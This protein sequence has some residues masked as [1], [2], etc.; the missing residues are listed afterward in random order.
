MSI[1][2]ILMIQICN[3]IVFP[4]FENFELLLVFLVVFLYVISLLIIVVF[5]IIIWF[6]ILLIFTFRN[7]FCF[8]LA[9]CWLLLHLILHLWCSCITL[10]SFVVLFWFVLDIFILVFWAFLIVFVLLLPLECSSLLI[11]I[12]PI[13]WLLSL[14]VW[15]SV[16]HVTTLGGVVLAQVVVE[17]IT[18]IFIVFILIT[19]FSVFWR[20]LWFALILLRWSILRPRRILFWPIFLILTLRCRPRQRLSI[21]VFWFEVNLIIA[22]PLILFKEFTV[23]AQTRVCLWLVAFVFGK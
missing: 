22:D 14:F 3:W 20:F 19:I 11:P 13:W 8:R 4:A 10:P 5:L 9:L 16:V 2:S 21:L 12:L 18:S 1:F 7:I 15:V 17:G 23:L 6:L